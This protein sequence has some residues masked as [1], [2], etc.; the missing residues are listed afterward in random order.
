MREIFFR[1]PKGL[2]RVRTRLKV[3]RCVAASHVSTV[4]PAENA[5]FP[6]VHGDRRHF[7]IPHKPLLFQILK[8]LLDFYCK[9]AVLVCRFS[10]CPECFSMREISPR[11]RETRDFS[12]NAGDL[13]GIKSRLHLRSKIWI[14]TLHSRQ[15]DGSAMLLFGSR[16]VQT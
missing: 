5:L 9:S 8:F 7:L 16:S 10:K 6:V 11:M 12:S 3:S 15:I 2:G 14:S 1:G 13:A 4:Y